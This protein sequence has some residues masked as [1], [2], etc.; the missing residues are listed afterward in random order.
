MKPVILLNTLLFLISFN[1]KA[2]SDTIYFDSNWE[3]TTRE[4]ARY[5]RLIDFDTTGKP[6][7][8]VKDFYISGNLQ[9]EGKYRSIYPDYKTGEFIYWYENGRKKLVCNYVNNVLSG[10]YVEWYDNGNLKSE[11]FL[12]DG[13]IEGVEKLWSPE[14]TLKKV[15]EYKNGLKHGKF[16]TFYDNGRPVRKDIF[17]N[18]ILVKGKCYTS[19]GKDTAYFEHLKPPQFSGGLEEFSKFIADKLIYPEVAK[20]KNEEGDVIVQFTIDKDGKI[21]NPVII[22]KDK[23]YFNQEAIRVIT[24]SP[25]WIPAQLDGKKIDIRITMPVRFRLK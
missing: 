25:P 23:E 3:Q 24:L 1:T 22:R 20:N 18:D 15:V 6:I 7:F 9:M 4:N 16:M 11:R 5:Y 12:K 14:G 2:G 13:I 17:K 21:I 19:Q 8:H 10:R